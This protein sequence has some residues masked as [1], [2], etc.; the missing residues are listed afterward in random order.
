MADSAYYG[1]PAT[2]ASLPTPG[3]GVSTTG[4]EVEG[5]LFVGGLSWQTTEESLR[6]HFEQY[7][8]VAAVELM[9][10]RTTGQP[11][12]FGF[13]VFKNASSVDLVLQTPVHEINH[14]VS[15]SKSNAR[16]RA[17]EHCPPHMANASCQLGCR[18]ET[19]SSEGCSPPIDS[20]GSKQSA[21]KGCFVQQ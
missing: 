12:G 16:G 2:A 8:Q 21:F 15:T 13:V 3:T 4:S 1:R 10:D 18:C 19:S 6:W 9:R 20:P 17:M 5:R 14:K 11:R 7:G